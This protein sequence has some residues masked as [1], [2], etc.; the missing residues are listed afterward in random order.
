[1][2]DKKHIKALLGLRHNAIS[3]IRVD[4]WKTWVDERGGLNQVRAVLRAKVLVPE[5][6]SLLN[7]ILDQPNSPS[8]FYASKLNIGHSSYFVYLNSLLQALAEILN[9]WDVE[10]PAQ[11]LRAS[12]LLTNLP[13]LLTP[14]I[15][16]EK[17]VATASA[18]LQNPNVRLL[19]LTGPGGV[20]KTR[21]A[22]SVSAG[23]QAGFRDGVFFVS[24]EAIHDPALLPAQ[25]SHALNIETVGAQSLLDVLR[26]YLRERQVLLVLDNFEQLMDGASFVTDL[27]RAA[28]QLKILVT[29]RE[30]LNVYGENRFTVPEL[31]R[32]APGNLPPLEQLIQWPAV[33]LFVQRV[34]ARHASFVLTEGNKEAVVAICNRLDG[35]PLAIELAAAQV[36]M[37]SPDQ[38]LPQLEHGLKSLRDTSR[39][40]PVR[41]KSLWSVIDWSYQLLSETEKALFRR[42]SVFG[43]EWSLDAAQMVCQTE[44]V[45]GNLENLIEKSLIRYAPQGANGSLRFQ[46][47]Q[48]VREYALDR[49]TGKAETEQTRRRHASYFLEMV[50]SAEPAIGTPEQLHWMR[51]IEQEWENIQIAL[52]W[53]L[54]SVETE[55]AFRLLGSIWRY[56]NIPIGETKA[57][58]DRALAQGAESNSAARVKTLWGAAWLS[59]HYNDSERAMRLAEQGL[60]LAREIGDQ[61][62]IAL[63][64]QNVADGL[65]NRGEYDQALVLLEESLRLFRKMDNQEEIA[66]ILGHTG[67]VL[68]QRGEDAHAMEILQESLAIFR[69]IGHQ[70]G[71]VGILKRIGVLALQGGDEVQAIKVAR[72]RL[73]ILKEIG[74]RQHISEAFYE[75]ASLLWQIG[76]FEPVQALVDESLALSRELGDWP[77]T[78]RALNFQGRLAVRRSDFA[79]ARD[80]FEQARVIFQQTGDAAGLADNLADM[81]RL[82]DG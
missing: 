38:G 17:S 64:L 14:L 79:A 68:L 44:D 51:R 32:P 36:K 33:H 61:K 48:A 7:L 11:R 41:Q 67:A 27:L 1:M 58:M 57:W 52:Q 37:L 55:L 71:V 39:D 29:S 26:A 23:L 10:Q 4:P 47:L 42:L 30:A 63:L 74:D 16:A 54:D 35:L 43:R 76:D 62:L 8:I 21:L 81:E 28:D 5:Q 50:E 3:I 59:T 82:G 66:W 2:W 22:L 60:A 34:Q 69:T 40:R 9:N 25:V 20:G 72:E 49:L 31:L 65:R 73:E 78:A 53:M 46:M 13:A 6:A 56:Y 45:L 12:A 75:L 15:G 24:L 80:F 70:M 77:G 19:T 18:I